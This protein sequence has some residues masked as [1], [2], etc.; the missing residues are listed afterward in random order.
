MLEHAAEYVRR[1]RKELRREPKF[2]HTRKYLE[3]SKGEGE[4]KNECM[5]EKEERKRS[6]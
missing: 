5:K 6:R 3:S 1:G 2:S 4:R